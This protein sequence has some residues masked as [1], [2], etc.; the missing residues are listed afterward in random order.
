MPLHRRCART[1]TVGSS[2][3]WCRQR[4]TLTGGRAACRRPRQAC[5]PNAWAAAALRL[6]SLRLWQHGFGE[7]QTQRA[8]PC[9]CTHVVPELC[10]SLVAWLRHCCLQPLRLSETRGLSGMA[11]AGGRATGQRGW[12]WASRQPPAA[13][14]RGAGMTARCGPR[15]AAPEG[16]CTTAGSS[17]SALSHETCVGATLVPRPLP[18]AR[19]PHPCKDPSGEGGGCCGSG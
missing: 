19:T 2:G 5:I 15:F 10:R 7:R 1:A 13:S 4:A 3:Q 18:R 17:A 9:L 16:H 12:G 14:R 6:A 8:F 11:A